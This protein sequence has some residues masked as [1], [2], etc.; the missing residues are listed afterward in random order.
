MLLL[1]YSY[2]SLTVVYSL[3]KNSY[4]GVQVSLNPY[5]SVYVV[6]ER[7]AMSTLKK[8]TLHLFEH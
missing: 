4:A 5:N 6:L 7:L 1:L 8:V 3:L 2:W